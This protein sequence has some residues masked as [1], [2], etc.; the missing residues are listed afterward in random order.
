MV[1]MRSGLLTR[2]GQGVGVNMLTMA[3]CIDEARDVGGEV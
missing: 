2:I 3:R 1:F